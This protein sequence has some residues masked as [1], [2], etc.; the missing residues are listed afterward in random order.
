VADDDNPRRS[1]HEDS[2]CV[3]PP[4]VPC[5]VDTEQPDPEAA[6]AFY[7]GLFG[8]E[9]ERRTPADAPVQYF[10]ARFRGHTV[11]GIGSQ[12]EAAPPTPVWTSYVCV[13]SADDAATKVKQAGGS[14]LAEPSDVGDAGRVVVVADRSGAT[15]GIWQPKGR[16]GV[17]LVNET[18]S[19]NSSSLNTPDLRAAQDFYGAVFGWEANS[20]ALE[21]DDFGFWQLPG[22]GDFLDE[23]NPG[24][25][26]AMLEMGAPEGFEDAVAWLV[27]MTDQ[28]PIHD[29]PPRWD[30]TF[31][32]ENADATAER[33]EQ[34][35]A[36]VLAPPMDAPWVRLTVLR[37]PQGAVFIA[38]QFVPPTS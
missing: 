31:G 23:L 4:G 18:G 16:K 21:A 29:A 35:G 25:S 27:P 17:E 34:L 33:A 5:W 6:T 9:F 19:W 20:V 10:I 14:V 36:T 32:V 38:S 22:Y 2:R 13:E 37:D 28:Q 15:F 26:A 24:T 30:I 7:G 12:P 3:P 11:A 8:W 1:D